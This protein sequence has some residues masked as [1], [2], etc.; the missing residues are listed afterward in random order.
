MR[1]FRACVI[2]A[3]VVF[4]Q[5]PAAAGDPAIAR[6]QLKVGY[7]LAQEGKCE[8]AIPH[9]VES[10]R[11]DPKAITLINLADCEEKVGKF[12]DAMGHWVDA[13]VRAQAESARPI[14]EEAETRANAL[15]PRLARLTIVL[16]PTAP[17]DAVVERD[18]IVLG[19]PSLGIPLP[20]DPGG[21]AIVV[22]AKGHP[23]S[24][25]QVNLLEGEQKRVEVDAGGGA[26][27]VT[28]S[29]GSGI[30]EAPPPTTSSS[31]SPLVFVGFGVAAAGLAVGGI[32]GLM[33]LNAG[34]EAEKDCPTLRCDQK[35]LDDIESGRTLGTISTIGFVVAGA[36]AA[37]GIYGLV[38]GGSKGTPAKSDPSVAV[39]FAPTG[40][41]LR[42][43]F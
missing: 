16:A 5:F 9:F 18:G 15:D 33:A 20:V 42:G 43:T 32:T 31:L 30:V 2:A 4:W 14:E 23:D 28:P 38:S 10:L 37:L 19:S 3:A 27:P 35:T 26:A 22:K 25:A 36:G 21:H 6:E 40:M 24:T 7:T 34:S 29:P 41:A 39:S 1:M 13:R 8:E 11:L 12:A 17:K